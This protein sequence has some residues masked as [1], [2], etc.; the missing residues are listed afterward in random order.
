MWVKSLDWRTASV[1]E[2]LQEDSSS[3]HGSAARFGELVECRQ[4]HQSW[5]ESPD[6]EVRTASLAA[7]NAAAPFP[8]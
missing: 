3:A 4:R 2:D 1:T 5:F 7:S 6:W 8:Q